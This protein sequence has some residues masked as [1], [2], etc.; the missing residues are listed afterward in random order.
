MVTAL[1][2]RIEEE[3]AA[4]DS[5]MKQSELILWVIPKQLA[6]GRRP[7][8]HHHFYGGS[9]RQPLFAQIVADGSPHGSS[10]SRVPH[11]T[12]H[13]AKYTIS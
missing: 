8:R 7:L 12:L 13:P 11:L 10:Y 3:R 1:D 6:G 2:R 5:K 4:I 9:S